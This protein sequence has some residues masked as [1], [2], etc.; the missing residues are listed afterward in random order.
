LP[1]L[2]LYVLHGDPV[3]R[4]RLRSLNRR[5][6]VLPVA[7][8]STLLSRV[9]GGAAGSVVVLD[10]YFGT[11]GG[12]ELAPPLRALR[13]EFPSCT[14]LAAVHL[15]P[16]LARDLRTM[17]EWGVAEIISLE[18]DSTPYKI[19]RRIDQARERSAVHTVL[20]LLPEGVPPRSRTVIEAALGVVA[21]DGGPAELARTLFVSIRTLQ[22]RC[23]RLGLPAPR[24]LLASL[25]LLLAAR[26]LDDPGR[27]VLSAALAAG[28]SSDTS[29]HRA[30]RRADL[31]SPSYLRN[32][33]ALRSAIEHFVKAHRIG[34]R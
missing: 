6:D 4:E 11:A 14:V 1:N 7:D 25:R 23:A 31:P 29:L 20:A 5:F 21:A 8:W 18:L 19:E 32:G 17:G 22:R 28:Y 34:G 12:G 9:S 15:D 24:T 16:G 10:P 13:R 2:P 3:L 30:L 26:F 27:T 33:R